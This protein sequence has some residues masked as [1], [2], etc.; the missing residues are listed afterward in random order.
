MEKESVESKSGKARIRAEQDGTKS[1]G[2]PIF[3][4]KRYQAGLWTRLTVQPI[5]E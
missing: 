2:V 5:K 3:G 4:K 1:V